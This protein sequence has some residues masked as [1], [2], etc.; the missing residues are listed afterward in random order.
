MYMCLYFRKTHHVL[1]FCTA[2][3]AIHFDFVFFACQLLIPLTSF[4]LHI[5]KFIVLL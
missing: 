3:F 4:D 5:D 2:N 1:L